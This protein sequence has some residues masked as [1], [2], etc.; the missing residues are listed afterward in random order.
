MAR[1][2]G[3]PGM[4]GNMNNLM[5]QAQKMQKQMAQMQEELE[6]KTVEATVG[7]GAVTAIVSGKKE[8]LEIKI[9]P[10]VVDEDDVEM[11]QDL[12]VAA[13]NEALRQAD[14]MVNGE[15]SKLTGGMNLPGGL[16]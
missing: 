11:L 1:R 13:V 6:Q 8:L 10:E 2:G 7:G 5:K 9:D 16:F 4:P 15:M 12:I 14:E 3:F